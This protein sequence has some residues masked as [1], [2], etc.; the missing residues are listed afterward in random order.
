MV[1]CEDTE[2]LCDSVYTQWTIYTCPIPSN[3]AQ[4]VKA[5]G[6]NASTIVFHWLGNPKPGCVLVCCN[7]MHH[8]PT[9][10][11]R[12]GKHLVHRFNFN[13]SVKNKNRTERQK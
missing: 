10:G 12:I 6:I 4:R 9:L 5:E 1:K 8:T 7:T 11:P 3:R 2:D 13:L